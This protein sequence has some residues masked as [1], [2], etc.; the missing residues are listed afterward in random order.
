MFPIFTFDN[1]ECIKDSFKF[2]RTKCTIISVSKKF[3]MKE[4]ELAKEAFD[5]LVKVKKQPNKVV[6]A[7][8]KTTTQLP[9]QVI[10]ILQ[11]A[12]LYISKGEEV[13]IIANISEY[14]TQEAADFLNVSRPHCIKLLKEGKIPYRKIGSHRR[15]KVSDVIAYNELFTKQRKEQLSFLTR[16]AQELKI[17][18]QK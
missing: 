10:K 6:I 13:S 17:G 14:T 2:C 8:N 15:I 9:S 12:L 3:T 4:Q 18:Y 11:D 5:V 16:Q 7:V 1:K